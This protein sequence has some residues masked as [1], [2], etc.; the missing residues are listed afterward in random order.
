MNIYLLTLYNIVIG[1]F[2][3]ISFDLKLRMYISTRNKNICLTELGDDLIDG[4][5]L[6]FGHEKKEI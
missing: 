2:C 5:V 1:N 3:K 4:F 6:G